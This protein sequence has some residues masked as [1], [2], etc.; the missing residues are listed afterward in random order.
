VQHIGGRVWLVAAD[1]ERKADI[2]EIFCDEVVERFGL[3]QISV[4]ALGELLRLGANFGR[5]LAAVFLELGVPTANLFPAL[6]GR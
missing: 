6:E 5:G 3:F 4:Q 1:S 2:T